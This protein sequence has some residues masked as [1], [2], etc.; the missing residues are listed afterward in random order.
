MAKKR[1]RNANGS[2]TQISVRPPPLKSSAI[3]SE[4][5]V[6]VLWSA[7]LA[8]SFGVAAI[9]AALVLKAATAATWSWWL[10]LAVGVCV[11]VVILA[12][13]LTVCERDRRELL[14]WPIESML[15]Q[16]LDADGFV[17]EPEPEPVAQ[18]RHRL[19]YVHNAERA[20]EQR[21]SGDFRRFLKGVYNDRGAAWRAW[22]NTRLPSGR[23][24]TQPLW[25]GWCTRL[26]SAGLAVRQH[27]TATLALTSSYREALATCREL[28]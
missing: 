23:V 7:L 15:G 14:L 26:L 19:I 5:A 16:D 20:I 4:V 2:V 21:D 12:W 17:G 10:P 28:L 25:E 24:V 1:N 13:R 22:E 27:P 8:M 6:P 3:E 11:G 18:E 9:L